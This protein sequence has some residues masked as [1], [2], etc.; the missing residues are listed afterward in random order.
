MLAAEVEESEVDAV[1]AMMDTAVGGRG[2]ISRIS[3]G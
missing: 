1:L 3:S 2:K